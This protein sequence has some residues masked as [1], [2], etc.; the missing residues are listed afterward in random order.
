VSGSCTPQHSK[1]KTPRGRE[2]GWSRCPY[3]VVLPAKIL[4]AA[5]YVRHMQTRFSS[6]LELVLCPGHRVFDE[7]CGRGQ[8][9]L[10]DAA[11]PSAQNV[12]LLLLVHGQPELGHV[13]AERAWFLVWESGW[14]CYHAET[15]GSLNPTRAS[16]AG[17]P[18]IL[19]FLFFAGAGVR[20]AVAIRRVHPPPR[21][22]RGL[23]PHAHT[24]RRGAIGVVVASANGLDLF[25]FAVLH[26]QRP[27]A[28][29]L[30]SVD[31]VVCISVHLAVVVFRSV[32]LW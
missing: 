8:V 26:S 27:S 14:S 13:S 10:L 30:D 6:V 28:A 21:P 25:Q 2:E 1:H 11:V 12:L 29:C 17:K 15:H 31:T 19:M 9:L 16:E 5:I 4:H 23:L 18:L 24:G 7:L 22:Q 3:L 32:L 20:A